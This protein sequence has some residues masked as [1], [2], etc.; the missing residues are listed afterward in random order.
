MHVEHEADMVVNRINQFFKENKFHIT[1]CLSVLIVL[2]TCLGIYQWYAN[3]VAED[4][5]RDFYIM[6]NESNPQKQMEMTQ[7]FQNKYQS[8][9]YTG[10]AALILI[11]HDLETQNWQGVDMRVNNLA[12]LD[13]PPFVKEQAAY[14]QIKRYL[15]TNQYK[16]A[17]SVIERLKE[18]NQTMALIYKGMIA[19]KLHQDEKA[20]KAFNQ[21]SQQIDAITPSSALNQFIWYQL[22]S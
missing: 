21:A 20:L 22:A 4:S 19:K 11:Q 17:A 9:A 3:K 14:L 7:A 8:G 10:L 18:P 2:V 13:V 1:L 5:A 16:Q 6:L 12:A 15:A